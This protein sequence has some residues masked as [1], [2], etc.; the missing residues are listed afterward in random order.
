M[1]IGRRWSRSAQLWL[2]MATIAGACLGLM[3]QTAGQARAETVPVAIAPESDGSGV[4]RSVFVFGLAP[5][6]AQTDTVVVSNLG[7]KT[8]N[9]R[10]YAANAFT[11][12]TG[13]IAVKSISDDPKVPATWVRF[14][15]ALG[16]GVLQIPPKSAKKVPFALYVPRSAPPG[17]YALG[18]AAMPVVDPLQPSSG[19]STI[20]VVTAVATPVLVRVDGPLNPSVAI[21]DF[22]TS[23]TPAVFPGL[24]GGTSRLHVLLVNNGNQKL[25]AKVNISQIDALGH[26]SYR[27]PEFEYQNLL[28]GAEIPINKGW[29]DAPTLRGRVRVEVTTDAGVSVV[30]SKAFW[31]IPWTF[32]VVVVGLL[33]ALVLLLRFRRARR[34]RRAAT[35]SAATMKVHTKV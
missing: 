15:N 14:T 18:L 5:G 1:G 17:D 2:V 13:K 23:A 32:I 34:I 8:A 3:P 28:P 27:F 16:D 12:S 33:L 30:R 9:V 24:A 10:L 4:R 25:T 11:T 31:S 26:V 7:D 19:Q 22:K 35:G 29:P 21:L 20:Q 6:S